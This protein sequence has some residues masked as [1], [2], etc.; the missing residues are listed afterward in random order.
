MDEVNRTLADKFQAL[1]GSSSVGSEDEKLLEVASNFSV[2]LSA[3]QLRILVGLKLFAN[4]LDEVEKKPEQAQI[5]RQFVKD[6]V[7]LK[8]Y[9]GSD[10]YVMRALDSISLRKFMQER[11]IGVDVLKR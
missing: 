3:S 6:Y 1:L 11:P 7:E 9:H 2:Q 10:F 5:L 8:K 4:V